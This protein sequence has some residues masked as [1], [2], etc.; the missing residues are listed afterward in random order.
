MTCEAT[1]PF[2]GC[3][4]HSALMGMGALAHLSSIPQTQ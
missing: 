4:A 2:T 1:C 3:K